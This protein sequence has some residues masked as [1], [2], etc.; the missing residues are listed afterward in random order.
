MGPREACRNNFHLFWYL[1][2]SVMLRMAKN[3]EGFLSVYSRALLCTAEVSQVSNQNSNA[4]FSEPTAH[5]VADNRQSGHH[6]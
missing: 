4:E 2:D 3:M 1:S 5:G 6:P